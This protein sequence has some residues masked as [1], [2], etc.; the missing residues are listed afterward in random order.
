MCVTL[1]IVSVPQHPRPG[2]VT[3]A[4]NGD[5]APVTEDPPDLAPRLEFGEILGRRRRR[6]FVPPLPLF[7]G[8]RVHPWRVMSGDV[9]LQKG[10]AP[11]LHNACLGTPI[12]PGHSSAQAADRGPSF[13]VAA[14]RWR[15]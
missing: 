1:I 4:L 11:H 14:G 13:V 9:R 15:F 8:A 12:S 6:R 10:C 2:F 5:T 3:L 7:H